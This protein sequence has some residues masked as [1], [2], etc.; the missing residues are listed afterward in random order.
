MTPEEEL[1]DELRR[2]HA[3][4]EIE[5]QPSSA[6]YFEALERR[7]PVRGSKIDWERV[8]GARVL[9]VEIT[10]SEAYFDQ[11]VAFAKENWIAERLDQE[12]QVVV[13]GDSAMEVALKMPL[14]VLETSLRS[15]L[16][17][18]EHNYVLAPDASWCM[19]F[20]MEGDMCFGHALR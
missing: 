13:V 7:F 14:R 18:P 6:G 16:R 4:R 11:A 19:V 20:T 10:A 9:H 17:M 5:V 3:S 8:P 1:L 15:I 2:R 12:Q